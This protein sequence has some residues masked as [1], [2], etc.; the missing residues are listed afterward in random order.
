MK[1]EGINATQLELFNFDQ[2]E[3]EILEKQKNKKDKI[4]A[5]LKDPNHT[6]V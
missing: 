2:K 4:I 1:K 5:D 3:M 6:I